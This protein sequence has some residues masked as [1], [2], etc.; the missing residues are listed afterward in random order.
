MSLETAEHE[1]IRRTC[2]PGWKRKTHKVSLVLAK[3]TSTNKQ[4]SQY[5]FHWQT[6]SPFAHIFRDLLRWQWKI[7]SPRK[8]RRDHNYSSG[9][10]WIYPPHSSHR[11]QTFPGAH[12]RGALPHRPN[13]KLSSSWKTKG[14]SWLVYPASPSLESLNWT[15]ERELQT[16]NANIAPG[17]V[18]SRQISPQSN[19]ARNV[20]KRVWT[21]EFKLKKNTMADAGRKNQVVINILFGHFWSFWCWFGSDQAIIRWVRVVQSWHQKSRFLSWPPFCV[22]IVWDLTLRKCLSALFNDCFISHV[23]CVI[24]LY[25]FFTLCSWNMKHQFAGFDAKFVVFLSQLI[26][27]FR[28]DYWL[29]QE[30]NQEDA[31]E[32]YRSES[33]DVWA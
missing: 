1:H 7:L 2:S 21:F 18:T 10:R 12:P 25:G 29:L 4:L 16:W 15:F 19:A 6:E 9:C 13:P 24:I 23:L 20:E 11:T 31:L 32:F 26:F 14:Q 33:A 28:L 8:F 5:L 22:P 27:N 17:S 3:C 30:A